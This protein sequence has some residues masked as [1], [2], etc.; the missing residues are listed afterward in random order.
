MNISH[1]QDE[2]VEL[3]RGVECFIKLIFS[4]TLI[5]VFMGFRLPLMNFSQWRRS[6]RLAPTV[7]LFLLEVFFYLSP[8]LLLLIPEICPFL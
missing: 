2:Y 6:C 5:M 8:P 4:L 7:H 3:V 1:L